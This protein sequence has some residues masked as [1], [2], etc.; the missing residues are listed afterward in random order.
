MILPGMKRISKY[1][2]LALYII[3]SIVLFYG[4]MFFLGMR[5][6]AETTDPFSALGKE[7]S[8]FPHYVGSYAVLLCILSYTG[9]VAFRRRSKREI[10][11]GFVYSL[12]YSVLLLIVSIVLIA[13]WYVS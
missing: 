3:F 4:F 9:T 12:F 6:D 13:L 7:F 1:H 8:L 11:K 5:V 2:I 10:Y